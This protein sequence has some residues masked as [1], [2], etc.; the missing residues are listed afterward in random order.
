VA[1]RRWAWATQ[2]LLV[3]VG[4]LAVAFVV[5]A[6]WTYYAKTEAPVQLPPEEASAG[7]TTSPRFSSIVALADGSAISPFVK[8]RLMP[9]TAQALSAAVAPSL[10]A[11]LEHQVNDGPLSFILR[12]LVVRLHWEPQHY[13]LLVSAFIVMWLSV[14]GFMFACERLVNHFYH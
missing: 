3:A 10:W 8:R 4:Y 7:K 1:R 14:V 13:P 6:L 2:R 9:E 11:G 12:P 5:T